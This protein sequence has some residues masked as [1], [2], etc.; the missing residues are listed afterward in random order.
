MLGA[1]LYDGNN[2]S[3]LNPCLTATMNSVL[4]GSLGG[5]SALGRDD[6]VYG[7]AAYVPFL[8]KQLSKK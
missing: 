6:P 7:I 8:R 2:F 1:P 4:L 3:Y 5:R